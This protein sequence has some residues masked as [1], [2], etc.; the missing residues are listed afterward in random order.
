MSS[1]QQKRRKILILSALRF[2]GDASRLPGV[3]RIA[4]IGSICTTKPNPKDI[5]LLVT[6]TSSVDMAKLAK[7]GR[8]LKGKSQSINCGADIFVVDATGNYLGRTCRWSDC[9]T[10]IRM[11]CE[12][13]NCGRIQY[14]YDDTQNIRL[15]RKQILDPP[16]VVY[17]SLVVRTNIPKDLRE[18]IISE[19]GHSDGCA[20]SRHSE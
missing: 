19:F 11:S 17:P 18:Q 2:V 14:L 15:D 10:G 12:A 5:D 6:T 7:L 13:L 8:R 20:P 4:I 1:E 16:V 9:R 3:E